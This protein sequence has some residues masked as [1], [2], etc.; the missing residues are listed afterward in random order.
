MAAATRDFDGGCAVHLIL[1]HGAVGI[2][3]E[4]VCLVVPATAIMG[5][6]L[7]VLR[8]GPGQAAEADDADASD[9]GS[10]A[11][12]DDLVLPPARGEGR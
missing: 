9:E 5:V 11:K 3:D 1:L 6:A 8:G 10:S 2:W 4:V 7:A 12:A